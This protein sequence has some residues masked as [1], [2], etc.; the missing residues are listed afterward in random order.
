MQALLT[1][2]TDRLLTWLKYALPMSLT[3]FRFLEWWYASDYHKKSSDDPIPPPPPR[4]TRHA[5]GLPLP[6]DPEACAICLKKRKN[7]AMTPTG[8]LF[9]YPCIYQHAQ[10]HPTCPITLAPMDASQIRKIYHS[11]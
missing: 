6:L 10:D 5:R 1:L 9:C 3:F 8:Y 4:L 2:T 7:P 11:T